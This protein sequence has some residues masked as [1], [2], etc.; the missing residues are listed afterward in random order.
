MNEKKKLYTIGDISEICGVPIKTLRYY[1][2]IKLLVPEKRDS[3]TNYRY[4][5]EEQMLVLHNIRKLK[6]YGFSLDEVYNLVY[7]SDLHSLRESLSSRLKD[8]HEK[9]TS[10]QELYNEIESSIGKIDLN[11]SREEDILI[12]E[13]PPRGLIY[14]KRMEKDFKNDAIPVCRWF[15]IFEIVRKNR[16]KTE[17]SIMATYH[18]PPLEQFLKTDCELEMSIAVADS[19]AFPFY[20]KTPGFRA[21]TS[22]H[23]GSHSGMINTYAK[24][25]K[26]L[27]TKGLEI[28]G[29]ITEEFLMSPTDV[30]NENEYLT[31]IIIPV[32]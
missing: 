31:K 29:P 32:K 25:I 3:E 6:N 21:V 22:F 20:K 15:E 17:S 10:Y 4:Y 11:I 26:W 8:I 16:L 24:A 9:I 23:K 12:E 27:N 5:T 18:N 7:E 2:E 19:P 14:T 1:D 13:I 30:K 28:S